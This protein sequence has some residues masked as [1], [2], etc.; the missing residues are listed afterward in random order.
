MN[1]YSGDDAPLDYDG[2][3]RLDLM[4]RCMKEALRL[5]PPLFTV[6]R[7]A[8]SPQVREVGAYLVPLG[9]VLFLVEIVGGT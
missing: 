7:L 1:T 9:A 5:R 4:D 3:K 6:M 2:L 8:E